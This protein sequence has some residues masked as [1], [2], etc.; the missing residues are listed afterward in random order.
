[1]NLTSQERELTKGFYLGI[2][3]G[4]GLANEKETRTY[5]T[6]LEIF[7]D[8]KIAC[9]L[10]KAISKQ[11]V[12]FSSVLDVLKTLSDSLHSYFVPEAHSL[13]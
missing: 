3:P 5:L 10:P 4:R 8:S 6:N 12:Q 9:S 7:Q 13:F 1:M 11:H 2:F